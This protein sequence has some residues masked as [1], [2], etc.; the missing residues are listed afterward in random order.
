MKAGLK[1][2][3]GKESLEQTVPHFGALIDAEPVLVDEPRGNVGF[4][5]DT[6]VFERT[7]RPHTVLFRAASHMA[8][9]AVVVRLRIRR[10]AAEFEQAV[11]GAFHRRSETAI[12]FDVL[13]VEAERCT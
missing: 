7:I 1:K 4:V 5:E 3:T 10:L 2:H 8:T 11:V 13:L 12:D 6:L 9:E